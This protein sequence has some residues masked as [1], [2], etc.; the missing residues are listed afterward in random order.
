MGII[1][2]TEKEHQAASQQIVELEDEK[3]DLL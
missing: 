3:S 2:E 1:K